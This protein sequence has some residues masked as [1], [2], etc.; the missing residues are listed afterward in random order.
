MS[1]A[2]ERERQ[3]LAVVDDEPHIVRLVAVNLEA[4]GYDTVS[5]GDGVAALEVIRAARPDLV[6]LDEMMPRLSGAQV[7]REMRCDVALLNTPV[8]A[9]TAM[10]PDEERV[11]IYHE[12]AQAYVQKPFN[13]GH[14]LSVVRGLLGVPAELAA[15]LAAVRRL[16]WDLSVPGAA[17]VRYSQGD[18]QLGYEVRRALAA[19]GAAA[20]GEWR[21]LRDVGEVARL[22]TPEAL[23]VLVGWLDDADPIH[24]VQAL[25]ALVGLG[26]LKAVNTALDRAA[27]VLARSWAT[28]AQW[29][30]GDAPIRQRWLLSIIARVPGPAATELLQH[31][32]ETDELGLGALAREW[33]EQRRRE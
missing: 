33:L 28:A 31:V 29:A 1:S 21:A 25:E 11:A 16:R 3:L 12:Y 8:V 17:L 13:P 2:S 20:L 14:L 30:D 26:G 23:A 22:A 15:E 18:P 5:A 27:D 9:L 7:L 24:A 4:A 10:R 32:A 19:R 6:V